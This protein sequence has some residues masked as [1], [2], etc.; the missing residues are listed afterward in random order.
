MDGTRFDGLTRALAGAKSR[1]GALALL[2][3]A[4]VAGTARQEAAEAIN[5]CRLPGV[6]CGSDD[7]CCS[8]KCDGGTCACIDAGK[9]C[10][11][12]GIACCSGRCRRG[13]CK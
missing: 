10:Y 4:A 13:K 11:Q 2:A 9:R 1:R 6:A 5:F 7:V 8:R 3:G 12:V